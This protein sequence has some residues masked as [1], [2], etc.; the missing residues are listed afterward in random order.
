MIKTRTATFLVLS[1]TALM[2]MPELAL[3]ATANSASDVFNT[4]PLDNIIDFLTGPVARFIAVLAVFALG[5]MIMFGQGFQGFGQ[6]VPTVLI[7]IIF[8]I[9]AVTAVDFFIGGASGASLTP[10]EFLEFQQLTTEAR[11]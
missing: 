2:G 3:A 5:A 10:E 6:R 11:D 9:G 7:G 1:A 8:V 4:G